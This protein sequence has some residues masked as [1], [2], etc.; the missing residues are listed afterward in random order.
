MDNLNSMQ[1]QVS[2]NFSREMETIRAKMEML[3]IK[4]T[5]MRNASDGSSVETLPLT[6]PRKESM[7][8]KM[9]ENRNYPN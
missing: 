2:S 3:E 6:Q 4:N 1:T 9:K 5:E 7:N 8:L